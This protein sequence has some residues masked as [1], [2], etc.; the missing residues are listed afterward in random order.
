MSDNIAWIFARPIISQSEHNEPRGTWKRVLDNVGF[1][2]DTFTRSPT[3]LAKSLG[4]DS[5]KALRAVLASE[6]MIPMPSE[7]KTQ[8]GRFTEERKAIRKLQQD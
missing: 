1:G 8:G 7:K 4:F 2:I 3:S 6:G 5:L